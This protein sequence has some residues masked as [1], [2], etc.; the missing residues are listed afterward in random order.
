MHLIKNIISKEKC[1][2]ER[3]YD[4]KG[5]SGLPLPLKN[6]KMTKDLRDIVE[7]H[8]WNDEIRTFMHV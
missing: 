2:V 1:K 7:W 6:K 3:L 8:P 5:K 4:V